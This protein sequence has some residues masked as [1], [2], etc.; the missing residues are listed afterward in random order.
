MQLSRLAER[1]TLQRV[2]HGVYALPSADA[3][4]FQGLRAAWLA[5][6]SR[7]AGQQSLAV[8]SG[9]SAA[10]VHGLGDL[11]PSKYEFSSVVRRQTSQADTRF[12]KRELPA[13]D[14]VWVDGLPVTSVARTL[15]D[16]AF[17]G[18]DLDHLAVVVRDALSMGDAVSVDLA[19]ALV[20]APERSSAVRT[21][22]VLEA[23]LKAS[24]YQPPAELVELLVPDIRERLV[25]QLAPHL[26]DVIS[27]ANQLMPMENATT[28]AEQL[29]RS[30]FPD[31]Q[32]LVRV[33]T[34]QPR[35][36]PAEPGSKRCNTR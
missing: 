3:G 16:L 31:S 17:G 33:L 32:T 30:A 20:P 8:V 4:P 5:T 24:G 19:R 36:E 10:A 11:L 13:E 18:T 15:Q 23:A 12:R 26:R 21:T 27:Q 28:T 25:A 2:R 14:V 35:P 34:Q 7:P 6:G 22:A 1:G 9:E 29:L